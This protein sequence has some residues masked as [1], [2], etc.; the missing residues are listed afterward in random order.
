M[1]LKI[2]LIGSFVMISLEIL[3]EYIA[4]IYVET[5]ARPPYIVS[6]RCGFFEDDRTN[7]ST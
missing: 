1:Q 3:G 4:K 7:V 2:L 6:S 5:K